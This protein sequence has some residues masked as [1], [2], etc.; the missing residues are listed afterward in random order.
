[1]SDTERPPV[2]RAVFLSYTSEDLAVALA[3]CDG[4]ELF[5]LGGELSAARLMSATVHSDG[6]K[7]AVVSRN[8]VWKATLPEAGYDILEDVGQKYDIS[9]DDQRFLM[10]KEVGQA[11]AENA[12]RRIFIVLNWTEELKRRVPGARK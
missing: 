9:P 4:K 2:S 10:L 1:M 11:A 5:Y 7:F 12:T 3:V 8:P 6:G